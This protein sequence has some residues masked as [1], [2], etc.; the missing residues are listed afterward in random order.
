MLSMGWVGD[1]FTKEDVDGMISGLRNEC[2]ATIGVN[3]P[4]P[5]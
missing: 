2:K 1:L 4:S 3:N 5:E